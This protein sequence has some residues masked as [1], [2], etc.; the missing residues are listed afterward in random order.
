[1]CAT[2]ISSEHVLDKQNVLGH[3]DL[4]S[5]LYPTAEALN[6]STS[7]NVVKGLAKAQKILLPLSLLIAVTAVSGAFVAGLDA[8]HAYNTFPL[9]DGQL[10]PLQYWSEFSQTIFQNTFE[11]TAAVCLHS[12]FYVVRRYQRALCFE[13]AKN[14]PDPTNVLVELVF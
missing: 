9:M 2:P 7:P 1:M 3:V 14:I 13:A 5:V 11:N 6:P 10:V 12:F 4:C 8:G